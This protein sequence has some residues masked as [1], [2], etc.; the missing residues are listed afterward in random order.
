MSASGRS[1]RQ[2][3]SPFT[4]REIARAP[5]AHGAQPG[6]P[7]SHL[8]ASVLLADR[9]SIVEAQ[10]KPNLQEYGDWARRELKIALD[11]SGIQRRY[12][13]NAQACQ[14]ALQQ[15]PFTGAIQTE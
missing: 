1:S 5:S 13:T 12:E 2:A 15:H 14:T 9:G 10:A 7:R 4:S 3:L 11:G 6:R 8:A